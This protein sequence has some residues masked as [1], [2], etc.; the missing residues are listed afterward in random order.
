MEMRLCFV[1]RNLLA[2]LAR[3]S[4]AMA[5]RRSLSRT[6]QRALPAE[7]PLLRTEGGRRIVAIM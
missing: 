3:R 7:G 5:G 6:I 2:G 1:K 4:P